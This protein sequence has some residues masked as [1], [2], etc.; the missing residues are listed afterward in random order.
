MA[1]PSASRSGFVPADV[2]QVSVAADGTLAAVHEA[3][4]VTILALPSGAPF[5]QIGVDPDAAAS[6]VA[7]VGTPGRLIVLARYEAHSTVHLLDPH[8]PRTI[9]EIRLEQPMRLAASVGSAAL[10]VGSQG[11]AVLAATETHLTLYPFPTRAVPLAAGAAATQIMVALPGSIE[12]WDPRSRLPKRRLR[13]PRVAAITAV[14]GSERLVWMTTRD[15]PARVD[16]IPLI[17]RGQPRA[18]DLPEP[19]ARTAGHPRSDLLVCVGAESGKLYVIDLDGRVPGYVT[20]ARGLDRIES[21]AL[22]IGRSA[23]VLVAQA[24]RP[25]AIVALGRRDAAAEVSRPRGPDAPPDLHDDVG[26]PPS[27]ADDA[28]ADPSRADGDAADGDA[29]DDEAADGLRRDGDAAGGSRW[30]GDAANASRWDGDV[31]EAASLGGAAT[32]RAAASSLGDDAH[33][34]PLGDD[35]HP[36]P[37]GDDAHPELPAEASAE[38]GPRASGL[39]ALR[40]RSALA[41]DRA[42]ALAVRTLSLREPMVPA[43]HSISNEIAAT[44][45]RQVARPSALL[46][47]GS[48]PPVASGLAAKASVSAAERFSAWRDLVRQHPSRHDPSAPLDPAPIVHVD[49]EGVRSDDAPSERVQRLRLDAPSSVEVDAVRD[50]PEG[51]APMVPERDDAPPSL[52]DDAPPSLRDDAP[53]PLRDDAPPSLRDDAPPLRDDTHT[54]WRDEVCAWRRAGALVGGAPV[55]PAIEALA[56]RFELAP[57]LQPVLA[58]LYGAHLCGE[59]GVAPVDVAHVLDHQWGEALGRGELAQRG[60]ASY[61]A[62]RVVLAPA[63]LRMLDELPPT[64]GTLVGA[65]GAVALLGACVAVAG[66]EP[67]ATI[68]ARCLDRVGGAVLAAYPEV[69]RAALAFEAR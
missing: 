54:S 49:A 48:A 19:I 61:A 33:P 21:A 53:G 10:V 11:A 52:R 34:G 69:E 7:W 36:G 30:D 59:H 47:R 29:A 28:A 32:E 24:G 63:V 46:P 9:A 58:M 27:R 38:L 51:A 23:S 44:P 50:D 26:A 8:G 42:T 31:A 5:A 4:R 65:P 43:V 40:Q 62:S 17:N 56:A 3:S 20:A 18:H 60:L 16:V 37:L 13:L 12:E 45:P 14:G 6:E 67:L 15:E 39:S 35:A 66:D 1:A 57:E 55:V 2:P 68:A 25:L 22:V 64:T 41:H